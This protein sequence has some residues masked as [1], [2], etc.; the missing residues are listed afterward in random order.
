MKLNLKLFPD[1]TGLYFGE[2]P[3]IVRAWPKLLT[4]RRVDSSAVMNRFHAQHGYC[5]VCGQSYGVK[6]EAHHMASGSRISDELTNLL[7][8][9]KSCHS[10][11]QSSKVHLGR[12][13]WCKW[14]HDRPNLNWVRLSL[15]LG[16]ETLPE[17][18]TTRKVANA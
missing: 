15:L 5:M 13:L 4:L 14:K 2:A 17:L 6:L 18:Q 9:C 12:C 7:M 16:Y 3:Q 1:S 10:E 8:V 11:V